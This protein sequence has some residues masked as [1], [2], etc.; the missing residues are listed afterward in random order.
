MRDRRYCLW[1]PAC[2][3]RMEMAVPGGTTELQHPCGGCGRLVQVRALG[4]ADEKTA[5]NA[6][7][8]EAASRQLSPEE[9]RWLVDTRPR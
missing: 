9:E 3:H 5:Y 8:N 2:S 1:C 4:K 6:L 7:M